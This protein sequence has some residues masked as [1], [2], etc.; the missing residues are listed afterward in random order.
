MGHAVEKMAPDR[1]APDLE[2]TIR[3][4]NYA[5]AS[6]QTLDG[7]E[8]Q[9]SRI[10]GTIGVTATWLDCPTSAEP[11]SGQAV[12]GCKGPVSGATMVLRILRGSPPVK[13]AFRDTTSGYA[14]GSVLASVFYG[15]IE[16]L[17][18]G[19]AGDDR[20]TPAILG[21]VIAH[22]LGHLLL[23]TNSHSEAG[24]MC[25]RW[26]R[27]YLGRALTGREVFTPE[28]AA[29]ARVNVLRRHEDATEGNAS[30]TGSKY[31]TL[32]YNVKTFCVFL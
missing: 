27:K 3:V 26:D 14:I 1:S 23:G 30:G 28:Q 18:Y 13:A 31:I 16:D 25:A 15:R 19:L 11:T 2:L 9:A 6:H 10:I 32:R 12:Q 8:H 20:Q 24:I 17:A 4:Y 7:A 22:E 5:G 21:Y 29:L